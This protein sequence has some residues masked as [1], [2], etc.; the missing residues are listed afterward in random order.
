MYR[1]RLNGRPKWVFFRQ[2]GE[3]EMLHWL[4]RTQAQFLTTATDATELMRSLVLRGEFQAV[5]MK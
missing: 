2:I 4:L 1:C 3:K 5:A